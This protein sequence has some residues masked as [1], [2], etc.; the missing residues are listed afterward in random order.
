[1]SSGAA[2]KAHVQ[3]LSSSDSRCLSLQGQGLHQF[4]SGSNRWPPSVPPSVLHSQSERVALHSI[5]LPIAVPDHRRVRPRRRQGFLSGTH[6][7]LTNAYSAPGPVT[8]GTERAATAAAADR[9]HHVQD[10][11]LNHRLL[12]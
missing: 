3:V 8:A 7:H 4:S 6:H 2:F 11:Y 9:K 12:L 1:M 5:D 10:T